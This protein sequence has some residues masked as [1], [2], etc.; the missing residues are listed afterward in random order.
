MEKQREEIQNLETKE[1]FERMQ[2]LI[3]VID[4]YR[5]D[6]YLCKEEIGKRREQISLEKES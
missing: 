2:Y 4:Y 6:L 3:Q 1:I 5:K